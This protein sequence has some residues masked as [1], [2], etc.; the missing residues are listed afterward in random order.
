MPVNQRLKSVFAMISRSLRL[1][2]II[3]FAAMAIVPLMLANF[4]S[5]RAYERAI[6]SSVFEKNR[7]F[8]ETIA[9]VVNQMLSEKIRMTRVAV[10][11]SAISSMQP[12]EQLP[13]LSSLV[14]QHGDLLI[15]LTTTASGDLLARSDGTH[16]I[17]NYSD[18]DYFKKAVKSGNT[19][20]SDVLI[21]KTT[22]KP[23]IAI[24]EPIIGPQGDVAGML[25]ITMDLQKIIDLVAR[26]RIGK[27]GYAFIVNADGRVLIHPDRT[28][29]D[30][31]AD[32]SDLAPARAVIGGNNGW[33]E[34]DYNGQKRLAGYHYLPITRWGLI[35]QQ[36]LH[37]A[38][39]EI[40]SVRQTNLGIIASTVLIVIAVVFAIAR[41][42]FKPISMLTEAARNVAAGNLKVH[43]E[44]SSTDEIGT[45]ARAFNN[46]TLQ[47]Q[48][49]DDALRRSREKYRR[50]VDTANEG[51]W[52][53][54]DNRRTSF[55]N[56]RMA[57][58]L[59]YTAEEMIGK[60]IRYFLFD[61]DMANHLMVMEEGQD[62][63]YEQRW[64]RR[65]GQELW[66]IVSSQT[67]IGDKQQSCGS[68]AMLT[69]ITERKKN[70]QLMLE[71]AQTDKVFEIAQN[72]QQSFLPDCP[73]QLEGVYMACR[74]EPAAHVGGDYYDFFVPQ[75]GVLD[76]VIADITGHNVGSALLM[77][78]TH[79]VLRALAHISRTPA[80]LLAEA[81]HHLYEDLLRA[82][83]QISMFYARFNSTSRCITYASAGHNRPL[84]Y[85]ART[86]RFT[87]LDAE[88]M[89][90]G[91][92]HQVDFEEKAVQVSSGD[93]LFMYTDG[94]TDTEDRLGGFFG[95]ERLK[96]AIASRSGSHP[97][98]IITHVSHVLKQFAEDKSRSDDVAM[99]AIKII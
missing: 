93:L 13:M 61:G 81:N 16:S 29:V 12:S 82:E 23:G 99:F 27:N 11:S 53:L 3:A 15:A 59:G 46:M 52:A 32:V 67:I 83:L 84:L 95:V 22:G 24:A 73:W 80:Q 64:R 49:R 55:V 5:S 74:C 33:V 63:Q 8:A 77:S 4:L 69:D 36:P 76:V 31:A 51:I 37:D 87:D 10:E 45:L 66:T 78:E 35:V 1:K 6:T 89:I 92:M 56:T 40:T 14:R 28:L 58:M 2:L 85:S 75:E 19:E 94:V 20:V 47:L 18:R 48:T 41:Y 42:L 9:G 50:I 54:D 43:A 60:E 7:K 90:L 21:S 38:L 30:N 91:V 79:I 88:G 26:T 17:I 65:D 97:Q 62:R 57:E 96:T 71:K 98:E 44:C 70:E 68:F 86:G 34:Y 72:I 25:I 39:H